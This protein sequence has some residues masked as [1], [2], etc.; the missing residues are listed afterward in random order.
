MKKT[1]LTKPLENEG[2][3]VETVLSSGLTTQ[4][5]Q[6]AN[7]LATGQTVTA[8]AEQLGLNRSTLYDWSKQPPFYCYVNKLKKEVKENAE[9]SLFSLVSDAARAVRDCLNSPD[10]KTRLQAAKFV[11]ESIAKT[12]IASSDP[13]AE[14]RRINTHQTTSFADWGEELDERAFK[15]ELKKYNLTE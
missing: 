1:T 12:E 15:A 9:N 11:F 7:L 14:L 2:A 4:Q 3:T 13:V 8:T 6:A 5:I 10:D